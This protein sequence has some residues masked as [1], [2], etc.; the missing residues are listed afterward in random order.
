VAPPNKQPW[1]FNYMSGK[2]FTFPD[3]REEAEA[4][5]QRIA[6]IA[7]TFPN[8]ALDRA[9]PPHL[10]VVVR[11]Q[12]DDGGKRTEIGFAAGGVEGV[13]IAV[14]DPSG[15]VRVTAEVGGQQV[16]EAYMDQ[17]YEEHPLWP[18]DAT[19][20]ADED[21]PGHASKHLWWLSL[22]AEAWP[23]LAGIAA[24]GYVRLEVPD[25]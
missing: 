4:L 25:R 17:P 23:S 21:E 24:D 10:P 1:F 13:L 9:E 2:E 18:P 6:W 5:V 14:P 22:R 7:Q 19:P 12:A 11:V 20:K 3:T 8:W 16:F 15:W